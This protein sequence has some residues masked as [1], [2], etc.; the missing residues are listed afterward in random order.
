MN[1]YTRLTIEIADPGIANIQVGG[2]FRVG[3][4]E[5]MLK[6]LSVSFDLD[7]MQVD[8]KRIQLVKKNLKK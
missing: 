7:V 3:E 5:A 4:T 1:R 8:E 2:Q 6:N